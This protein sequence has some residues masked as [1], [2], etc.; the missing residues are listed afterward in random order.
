MNTKKI[1]QYIP[2]KSL[3]EAMSSAIFK[4]IYEF[5]T[6]GVRLLFT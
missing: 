6:L 5:C 2:A 3:T 4:T 1:T